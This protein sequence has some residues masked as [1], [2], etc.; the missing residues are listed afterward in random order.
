L[1]KNCIIE[2]A[3]EEIRRRNNFFVPPVL[4]S[5]EIVPLIII[6]NSH[7]DNKAA[8]NLSKFTTRANRVLSN[9]RHDIA[10]FY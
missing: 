10:T 5:Q 3:R 2:K 6:A 7:V 1:N 8:A 4:A 9:I